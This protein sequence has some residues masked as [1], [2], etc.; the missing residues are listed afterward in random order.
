VTEADI[1]DEGRRLLQDA[2]SRGR[3]I[4]RADWR[5]IR[6]TVLKNWILDA[7][8]RSF[9][10]RRWGVET[11]TQFLGLFP[12]V[13]RVD[14]SVHPPMVELLSEE[15]ELP[16]EGLPTPETAEQLSRFDQIRRDLWIAVLDFS[17]GLTYVMDADGEAIGVRDSND[18]RPHLPTIDREVWSKWR[19]AFYQAQLPRTP[20]RW[21]PALQ[22]WLSEGL[23]SASLPAPLRGQWNGELKRDVFQR[24]RT[25][26]DQQ[27][28]PVPETAIVTI[29]PDQA[30]STPDVRRLREFAH[31]TIEGMTRAELEMLQ[32][33][34]NAVL[35]AQRDRRV[36]E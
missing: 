21:V 35:R 32:L 12:D 36:G 14:S 1:H 15:E 8:N 19:Q 30:S 29:T 27:G 13:V 25:W 18:P 20:D 34:L 26:F 9:D 33:P 23:P 11:F 17:S 31:Q 2:F 24:L 10:E 7:T 3:A 4:G 28:L 5:R 22:G 6:A 16:A